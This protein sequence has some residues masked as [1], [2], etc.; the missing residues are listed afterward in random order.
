V[1]QFQALA[2]SNDPA[3]V[4]AQI[5]DTST[6]VGRVAAAVH[7]FATT[8]FCGPACYVYNN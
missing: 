7:K 6:P 3:A 4:L 8:E 2:H 1:A 5:N